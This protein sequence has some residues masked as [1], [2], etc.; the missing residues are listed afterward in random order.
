MINVEIC[1]LAQKEHDKSNRQYAHTLHIP[2]TI[3]ISEELLE[4]PF[5]YVCGLILHEMGHL[6]LEN[7]THTEKDADV[8]GGELAGVKIERRDTNTYGEDLEY[9]KVKDIE[10]AKEYIEENTNLQFA[11]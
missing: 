5:G 4:L 3:C 8:I 11:E 9:V 1:P 7:E 10:I 6:E 2:N